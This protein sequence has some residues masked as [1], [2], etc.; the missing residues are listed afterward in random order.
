MILCGWTGFLEE[1]DNWLE[2]GFDLISDSVKIAKFMSYFK[3]IF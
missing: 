2:T 1:I 3:N